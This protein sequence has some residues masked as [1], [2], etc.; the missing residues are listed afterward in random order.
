M[1]F[2]IQATVESVRTLRPDLRE[3]ILR[4][5]K[6]RP[7]PPGAFAQLSLEEVSASD[8]WPEA[9]CF[10]IASIDRAQ[11][12][13]IIQKVGSYTERIFETLEPGS[14]CTLKYPL[15]SM[16]ERGRETE[17]QLMLAGGVG[18]TPFLSMIPYFAAQ[19]RSAQLHLLYSEKKRSDCLYLNELL[20]W[21]GR[22]RLELFLTRE[23][24]AVEAKTEYKAES[25]AGPEAESRV[26]GKAA[27]VDR[28]QA[29]AEDAA[30]ST[31]LRCH[32]RRISLSDVQRIAEPSCHIY[33][34]GSRSFIQDYQGL[35]S[36][37]GYRHLYMDEWE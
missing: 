33:L 9:R 35:L 1:A 27:A 22:D 30:D 4:P 3:Y 23:Q 16:Y 7:Y 15:G 14:R 24:P 19:G 36:E 2:V 31:A 32:Y 10:S 34:C 28:A 29:K 25:N 8:I 18:I 20:G 6:A 12:R 5:D 37:A 11:L 17:S 21:L 26:P 13:L